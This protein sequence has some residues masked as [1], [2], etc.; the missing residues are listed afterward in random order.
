[1][2]WFAICSVCLRRWFC[3]GLFCTF[4]LLR[5]VMLEVFVKCMF[6][7]ELENERFV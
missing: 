5:I 1:M 2:R 7:K 6:G 3:F 4:E